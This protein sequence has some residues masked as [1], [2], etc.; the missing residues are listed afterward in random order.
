VFSVSCC[1]HGW[2]GTA[3]VATIIASSK[4]GVGAE[5]RRSSNRHIG[6]FHPS[7]SDQRGVSDFD[8]EHQRYRFCCEL[9]MDARQ[10]Q[11]DVPVSDSSVSDGSNK[12]AGT[13]G[14]ASC[15]GP[16]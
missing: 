2:H 14:T 16:L 12:A 7:A 3:R 8:S 10:Q 4:P 1:D 9:G 15:S 13:P 5:Q 6:D 11:S